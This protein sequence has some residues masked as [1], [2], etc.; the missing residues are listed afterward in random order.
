VVFNGLA[1]IGTDAVSN[2]FREFLLKGIT[3]HVP[4]GRTI[5]HNAGLVPTE[6]LESAFFLCGTR[7][8]I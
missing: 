7:F 1:S 2:L 8:L 3:S 6:F 4:N 5:N